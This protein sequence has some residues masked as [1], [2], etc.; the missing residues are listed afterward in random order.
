[1]LPGMR[2]WEDNIMNRLVWQTSALQVR[3]GRW[4]AH[5]VAGAFRLE[6]SGGSRASAVARLHAEL[7]RFE[8]MMEVAA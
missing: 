1:M 2:H 7:R 5:A 4:R 3:P 8:A 6:A